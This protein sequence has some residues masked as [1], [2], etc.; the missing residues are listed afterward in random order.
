MQ[1][2]QYFP[3]DLFSGGLFN[4][5]ITPLPSLR[6]YFARDFHGMLERADLNYVNGTV[7][8]MRFGTAH[9]HQFLNGID[10]D[11]AAVR[12]RHDYLCAKMRRLLN[13][14]R[15]LLL[16]AHSHDVSATGKEIDAMLRAYNPRLDYQLICVPDAVRDQQLWRDLLPLWQTAFDDAQRGQTIT[17]TAERLH[18]AIGRQLRRLGGHLKSRRF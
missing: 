12:E 4:F 3:R 9:P 8:N 5:Q 7:Q 2:Q 15:P 13:A 18:A 17:P 6:E 14:P 16:I 11:Y 10:Q 1:A